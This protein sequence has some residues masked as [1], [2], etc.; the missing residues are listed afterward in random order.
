[1]QKVDKN[2]KFAYFIASK[3]QSLKFAIF[4]E[5]VAKLAT[6]SRPRKVNGL[7]MRRRP[8]PG[9]T[10]TKSLTVNGSPGPTHPHTRRR[11]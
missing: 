4:N 1:M 9:E 5:K 2:G 7:K 6:L 11:H 8:R 10:T 3:C